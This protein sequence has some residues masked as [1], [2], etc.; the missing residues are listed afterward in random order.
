MGVRVGEAVRR[1]DS[2]PG[3]SAPPLVNASP[4]LSLSFPPHLSSLD[5]VA[6]EA[7]ASNMARSGCSVPLADSSHLPA[8]RALGCDEETANL[9]TEPADPFR[10]HGPS[11]P[12]LGY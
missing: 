7:T 8:S 9:F 10:E 3:P 11:F 5:Q 4:S 6:P 1:P 12:E 2:N